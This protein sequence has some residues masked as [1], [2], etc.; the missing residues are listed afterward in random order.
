[1]DN[2]GAAVIFVTLENGS[3][4]QL[5]YQPTLKKPGKI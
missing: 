2:W 4:G 3:S 1:M 5:T